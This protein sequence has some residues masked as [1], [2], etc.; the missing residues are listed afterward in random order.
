MLH[1]CFVV[2]HV[3][4]KPEL[5]LYHKYIVYA[6]VVHPS[7]VPDGDVCFALISYSL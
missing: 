6:E 7:A 5:F 4:I 1:M 3:C 2:T